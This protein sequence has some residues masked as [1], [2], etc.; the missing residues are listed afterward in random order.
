MEKKK[1][2]CEVASDVE[3][4]PDR[5]S[6][7]ICKTPQNWPSEAQE[8]EALTLILHQVRNALRPL[9]HLS[10]HISASWGRK[11]EIRP[12]HGPLEGSWDPE[13]K[14]GLRTCGTGYLRHQ[15]QSPSL[16]QLCNL[17]NLVEYLCARQ[18]NKLKCLYAERLEARDCIDHK[19]MKTFR[20]LQNEFH[21]SH[22]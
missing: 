17:C 8:A 16:G 4:S 18:T 14:G 13:I 11:T 10:Y 19:E 12:V 1:K 21:E 9:T 6:L 20:P 3:L 5:V 7:K 15:A 2:V 22:A